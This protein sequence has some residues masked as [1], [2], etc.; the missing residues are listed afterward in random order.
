MAWIESH[1]SLKEHPKTKRFM[2][3]LGISLPAAIGHLHLMW[4]YCL[5]YA[6]DGDLSFDKFSVEDIADMAQWAGDALTFVDALR[7][8]GF[9]EQDGESLLIHDWSDYA[10]KLIDRRERNAQAMRERRAA[11]EKPTKKNVRNTSRT[12]DDTCKATV[13]NTTQ[14]NSTQPRE[15]PNG[16]AA[17]PPPL[18]E[19]K[20]LVLVLA[21]TEGYAADA[22]LGKTEWGRLG[23][24][25]TELIAISATDEDVRTRAERYQRLHPD[26]DYTANALVG[27][28]GA[29]AS[30]PPPR[31]SPPA[32]N[33]HA[34]ITFQEQIRR[35]NAAADEQFMAIVNG[36]THGRTGL[37]SRDEPARGRLSD[38]GDTGDAGR[39]VDGSG[40][41]RR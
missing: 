14:Q 32:A 19:H 35:N 10:G 21:E 24:A 7:Q 8:S 27:R 38:G 25:A 6:P 34:P 31:A 9:L 17:E 1:Q 5:D 13:P 36:A 11:Q 18:S 26:W 22:R 37:P 29:L 3:A 39:V 30:E 15:T 2:R 20:R 23:K 12:R 40:T 16:V 33:G 4:W 28:W 41:Q